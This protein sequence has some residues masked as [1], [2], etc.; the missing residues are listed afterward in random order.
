MDLF[1]SQGDLAFFVRHLWPPVK[2][3]KWCLLM[4]PVSRPR[5][6]SPFLFVL[7]KIFK[8]LSLF[9]YGFVSF[10]SS[11]SLSSRLV[12]VAKK[13]APHPEPPHPLNQKDQ[14]NVS[15]KGTEYEERRVTGIPSS[16][17]STG[18]TPINWKEQ[19]LRRREPPDRACLWGD[20]EW[21]KKGKNKREIE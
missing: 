15:G 4:L 10:Y 6:W 18:T 13:P 21:G 7:K 8:P 5:L 19:N 9:I 11:Y 1:H 14:Q 16:G 3:H 17:H 2:C 20:K 12:L